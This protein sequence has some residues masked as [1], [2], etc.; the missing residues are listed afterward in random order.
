MSKPSPRP[1]TI[2][3]VDL[4]GPNAGTLKDFYATV[5]GWQAESVPVDGHQD[6]AV[7]P[8]GADPVAGI[9]H[10]LPPNQGLP[11]QWL[12]YIHVLDLD[13]AVRA[14]LDHGG[15][16]LR[17]AQS[18]QA[19]RFAVIRDPVGAVCALYQADPLSLIHI[20]EPTRPY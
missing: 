18:A 10:D 17:P 12:I 7:G 3:W 4:T 6:Y 8:P 11:A 2:G 15:E 14:C 16:V 5:V 19:P 1:G 9:C 13:A 20:S